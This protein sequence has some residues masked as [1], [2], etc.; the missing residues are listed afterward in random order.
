M[1]EYLIRTPTL[2]ISSKVYNSIRYDERFPFM[3]DYPF[4]LNLLNAGY[5]YYHMNTD[6]IMYRVSMSFVYNG[7]LDE[8]LFN[9]FYLTHYHFDKTY[10]IK[11]M[12]TLQKFNFYYIFNLKRIFDTIG[13]NKSY[14]VCFAIYCL[15]Y[16]S[17]F[18]RK[19][20]KKFYH[21]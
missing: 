11:H 14:P 4:M 7:E 16:Y 1:N 8:K 13:M 21:N 17:N 18:L 15:L 5:K 19:I 3:E 2:F 12:N 9:S 10:W 6:T 20:E